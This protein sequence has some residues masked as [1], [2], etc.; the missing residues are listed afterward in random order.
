VSLGR[1]PYETVVTPPRCRSRVFS[2]PQRFPGKSELRGLVSCRYRSWD[3]P[4]RA[5]PSSR[6]LTPLGAAWLPCSYPPACKDARPDTVSPLVSPTT[7]RARPPGFPTDYELPFQR[8]EAHLPG[9]PGSRAAG[10]PRPA[11]FTYFEASLPL[12]VRSLL[13]RVSPPHQ[14]AALLGF[15]PS[16]VFSKRAWESAARQGP[17]A[18]ARPFAVRLRV[19][20]DRAEALP[21]R[22]GLTVTTKVWFDLLDGFQP[23]SG[24]ARTTSRWR[25]SSPDLGPP[26]A[27]A[28]PGLQSFSVTRSAAFPPRR[29][30]L[31]W[32]FLPLRQPRDCGSSPV[33][34]YRFTGRWARVSVHPGNLRTFEPPP[35]GPRRC[36]F[37]LTTRNRSAPDGGENTDRAPPRQTHFARAVPRAVENARRNQCGTPLPIPT[38]MGVSW[39]AW[40]LMPEENL[41]DFSCG[42]LG[43]PPLA[44]ARN[45]KARSPTLNPLRGQGFPFR[46]GR[47]PPR[48][49][50]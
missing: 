50:T 11:S 12:R 46:A 32:G 24:L 42:R 41:P 33:L 28:G 43:E 36:R 27:P 22:L 20:A 49:A 15:F 9:R 39:R 40:G 47:R 26:G 19:A 34:A 38:S 6:S 1:A 44:H 30:L 4:F 8:A 48:F 13:R 14:A 10:P 7:A 17:R 16:R 21:T 23:P 31:F 5:F 35:G 45:G 37:G 25:S 18:Q 29:R 2:T 3:P